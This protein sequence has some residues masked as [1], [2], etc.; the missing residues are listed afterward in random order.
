MNCVSL[1][2]RLTRD[3]ELKYLPSGSAVVDFSLALPEV[4]K[5]AP[6]L[7][8]DCVAFGDVAE[9]ISEFFKKGKP[10]EIIGRLSQEQWQD[11][12]GNTRKKHK[13][14]VYQFNF[15]PSYDNRPKS[16]VP[17]QEEPVPVGDVL[18]NVDDIPF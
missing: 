3:I 10:I 7:F 18:D 15:F 13:V 1:S 17:P 5:D 4:K 16:D 2:G 9:K 8:I 11:R 14:V 12:E 6:T